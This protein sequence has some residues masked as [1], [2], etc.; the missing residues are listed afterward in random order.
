MRDPSHHYIKICCQQQKLF[1]TLIVLRVQ[2]F[3][4]KQNSA[5]NYIQSVQLLKNKFNAFRLNFYVLYIIN[6]N[7]YI[8]NSVNTNILK[9]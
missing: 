5:N 7:I 4:Y 6:Y 1:I 2:R 3:V 8:V 9:L